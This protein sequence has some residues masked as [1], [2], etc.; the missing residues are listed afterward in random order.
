MSSRV[1]KMYSNHTYEFNNTFCE[2]SRLIF[3]KLFTTTLHKGELTKIKL[4]MIESSTMELVLQYIYMRQIEINYDNVLDIMR[5]ASYLYI[6]SLVQLCQE[7]AVECLRPDNCVTLL[8]FAKYVFK[9]II[10]YVKVRRN[11]RVFSTQFTV[12][13]S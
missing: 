10:V 5:V 9:N 13:N 11:R 6:D 2:F 1:Y 3:R 7:F 4:K 12:K 8:Q